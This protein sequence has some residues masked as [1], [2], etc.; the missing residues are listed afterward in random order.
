MDQSCERLE[1]E[2]L[3][4]VKRYQILDSK[5][6]PAFDRLTK[7]AAGFFDVPI[8]TITFV[9]DG[10]AWT[11]AA[12]GLA[13]SEHT[14]MSGFSTHVVEHGETLVIEDATT[15]QRF[16]GDPLV[17]AAPHLRFHAG[18]PLISQTGQRIGALS[19]ADIRP[20]SNFST[21]DTDRLQDLAA[22]VIEQLELRLKH[23][24]SRQAKGTSSEILA[25]MSH[26]IRTPMNGVLGMAELLLIADDLGDRHR[27][28]VEI[29]KRSGESLLTMLD[30]IIELSRLETEDY[31]E[32]TSSFDL[33]K[34]ARDVHGEFQSKG[35]GKAIEL[36]LTMDRLNVAG[37]I[38]R[39][40]KL[41]SCFL[42]SVLVVSTSRPNRLV[43]AARPTAAGKIQVRFEFKK[44]ALASDAIERMSTM[45][46][47]GDRVSSNSFS[48]ADLGLLICKRLSMMMGGDIGVDQ[49]GNEGPTFWLELSLGG[50]IERSSP[51]NVTVAPIVAETHSNAGTVRD[52]LLAEDNPDMALLIEDLLDEAGYQTTVAPDGASALR[53][54]EERRIDVVLMDGRLPDMS[55]FETA[56]LIRKLPDERANIPIIALTAE[57]LTGDRE[58]YLSAGMDDYIAKPVDYETLVGAIERC[59]ER[60]RR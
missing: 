31:A 57:A 58:R 41:F 12:A 23:S 48:E 21:T 37:D 43:M 18:A 46:R 7:L 22:L 50:H 42:N 10:R 39:F 33:S 8:A 14:E 30:H 52:V 28:R 55:G 15:D 59:C 25:A 36:E 27:R 40:K 38:P 3:E 49:L 19:I 5:P 6:E 60:Q 24:G 44:A 20:R 26:D 16:V 53:I 1:S 17:V 54:L 51:K 4:A 29:I 56:G 2:R 9:A 11:K 13:V 45:F 32:E 34:V 35:T 47:N